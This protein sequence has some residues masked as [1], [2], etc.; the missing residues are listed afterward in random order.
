MVALRK[1]FIRINLLV[2]Y[3]KVKRTKFVVLKDLY[4]ILRNLLDH[5]TLDFIYEAIASFGLFMISEEHCVYAKKTTQGIMFLTPYVD[6]ILLIGNNMEMINATKHGLS[7]I[8][9]IK[10]TGEARYVLNTKIIR[11]C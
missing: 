1:R 11:N 7:S 8:L 3:Q 2:F 4:M 10:D 9:K 5:G 6:D